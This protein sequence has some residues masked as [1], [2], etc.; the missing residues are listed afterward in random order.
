MSSKEF[1]SPHSIPLEGTEKPCTVR[2]A[3]WFQCRSAV[4]WRTLSNDS[5]VSSDAGQQAADHVSRSRP[6]T[7]LH[8]PSVNVA[9]TCIALY[10]LMC[11]VVS[12]QN[13]QQEFPA[14]WTELQLDIISA[15]L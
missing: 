7:T 6:P 8:S 11:F 12:Q 2:R 10:A 4:T 13:L 15:S 1:W 5:A 14:P 3:K 9:Q